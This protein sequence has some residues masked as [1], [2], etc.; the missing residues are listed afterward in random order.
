M[1]RTVGVVVIPVRQAVLS[2]SI[3]FKQPPDFVVEQLGIC[4]QMRFDRLVVQVW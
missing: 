3:V 1:P 4:K 2:V